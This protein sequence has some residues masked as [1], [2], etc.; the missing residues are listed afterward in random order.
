M[1]EAEELGVELPSETEAPQE[2]VIIQD[3]PAEFD[4]AKV[5]SMDEI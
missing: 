4:E 1:Y 3:E 2:N 5:V